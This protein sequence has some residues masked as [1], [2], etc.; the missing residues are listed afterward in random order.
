MRTEPHRPVHNDRLAVLRPQ[1]AG[2]AVAPLDDDRPPICIGRRGKARHATRPWIDGMSGRRRRRGAALREAA[3][4]KIKLYPEAYSKSSTTRASS[5]LP[6]K[7]KDASE[8]Q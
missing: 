3:S 2:G 8:N 7:F 6:N 1:L 4:L 5:G